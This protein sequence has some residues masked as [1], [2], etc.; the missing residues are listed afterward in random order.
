[1]HPAFGDEIQRAIRGNL[2]AEIYFDIV[3]A[4][5]ALIL[6]ASE[7]VQVS[8]VQVAQ[9]IC[10]ILSVV[11]DCASDLVRSGDRDDSAASP[12]GT[13]K[14]SSVKISVPAG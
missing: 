3:I 5:D 14:R 8:I 13:A 7:G 10:H 12:R 9:N 11:V 2:V 4:R 1:M 6:A